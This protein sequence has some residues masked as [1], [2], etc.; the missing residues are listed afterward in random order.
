MGRTGSAGSGLAQQVHQPRRKR[1][2]LA[3]GGSRHRALWHSADAA[4]QSY[5]PKAL[6]AAAFTVLFLLFLWS[7]ALLPGFVK[8]IVAARAIYG[9]VQFLRRAGS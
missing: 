2:R 3:A 5:R 6:L 4:D 8:L 9:F 7:Q 1:E